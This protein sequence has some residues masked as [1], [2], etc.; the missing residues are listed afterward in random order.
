MKP[1]AADSV[2]FLAASFYHHGKLQ[3]R[4]KRD[5]AGAA[6]MALGE[7]KPPCY[8]PVQAVAREEV[9]R[10][11]GVNGGEAEPRFPQAE[12]YWEGLFISEWSFTGMSK[13]GDENT[14]PETSTI[15][16]E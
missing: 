9:S 16:D 15:N 4:L 11:P 8:I 3:E 13:G 1:V 14:I 6:S 5:R 7:P 2:A 10:E 12:F